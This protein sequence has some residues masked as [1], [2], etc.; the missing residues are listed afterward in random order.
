[1]TNFQQTPKNDGQVIVVKIENQEYELTS[2][3]KIRY[4]PLWK[5]RIYLR[6]IERYNR[7]EL[8]DEFNE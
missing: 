2:S 5:L 3:D 4:L 7:D 6:Y 8:G 1:M